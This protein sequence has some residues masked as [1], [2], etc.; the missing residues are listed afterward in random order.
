MYSYVFTYITGL[1]RDVR[2]ATY[3]FKGLEGAVKMVT[4]NRLKFGHI[5]DA[6]LGLRQK[7][8]HDTEI[9]LNGKHN[10]HI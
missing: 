4:K 8:V 9:A 10:M 2:D 5:S 6:E 7:Y 1:V 3:D